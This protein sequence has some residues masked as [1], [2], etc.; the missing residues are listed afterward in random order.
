M[1]QKCEDQSFFS[2]L[3]SSSFVLSFTFFNSDKN[4]VTAAHKHP[5]MTNRLIKWIDPVWYTIQP[6]TSM[7][8]KKEPCVAWINAGV[9]PG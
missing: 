5:A 6:K 9:V 2:S 7:R 3:A 8:R 1:V 4:Q